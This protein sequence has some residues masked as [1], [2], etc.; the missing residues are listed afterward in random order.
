MSPHNPILSKSSEA[1]QRSG[2]CALI[3]Q[4][5]GPEVKAGVSWDIAIAAIEDVMNIAVSNKEFELAGFEAGQE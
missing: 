5:V 4:V 3:W 2:L 1:A